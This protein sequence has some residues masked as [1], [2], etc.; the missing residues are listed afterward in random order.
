MEE[1]G[2][3]RPVQSPSQ[4]LLKPENLSLKSS[5][6]E[7]DNKVIKKVFM[8]ELYLAHVALFLQLTGFIGNV[9]LYGYVYRSCYIYFN[10]ERF[11]YWPSCDNLDYMITVNLVLDFLGI[12]IYMYALNRAVCMSYKLNNNISIFSKIISALKL[13]TFD[14]AKITFLSL[15]CV[16]YPGLI[17]NPSL[18]DCDE[19]LLMYPPDEFAKNLHSNTFNIASIYLNVFEESFELVLTYF[20]YRSDLLD[21]IALLR[22]IPSLILWLYRLITYTVRVIMFLV[23]NRSEIYYSYC[24]FCCGSVEIHV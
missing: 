13:V 4:P 3:N 7:G 10:S 2:S 6:K 8:F 11:D 15:C 19:S 12:L 20:L 9:L 24:N 14:I 21:S 22:I 16:L 23:N 1:S 17:R 18:L 5:E